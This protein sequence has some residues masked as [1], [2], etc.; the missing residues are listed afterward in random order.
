MARAKSLAG[1]SLT[2][3]AGPSDGL[4]QLIFL[5]HKAEIDA[6]KVQIEIIVTLQF[7]SGSQSLESGIAAPQFARRNSLQHPDSPREPCTFV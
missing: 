3:E 2:R 1:S 5:P 7:E 6:A 4:K